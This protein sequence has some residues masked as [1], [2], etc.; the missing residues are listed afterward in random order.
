MAWIS[1]FFSGGGASTNQI[2][3]DC[4]PDFTT[5]RPQEGGWNLEALLR[6]GAPTMGLRGLLPLSGGDSTGPAAVLGIFVSQIVSHNW[7]E[8]VQESPVSLVEKPVV[9]IHWVHWDF[10][11]WQSLERHFFGCQAAEFYSY[12]RQALWHSQ[13]PSRNF[14]AQLLNHSRGGIFT[15]ETWLIW[16]ESF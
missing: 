9:T 6:S 11:P 7:W 16:L 3:E 1:T 13:I 10:Q 15:T 4:F 5:Q 2:I 14:V 8:N 12:V